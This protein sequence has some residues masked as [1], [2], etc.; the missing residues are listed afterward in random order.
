[1]KATTLIC[2][3]FMSIIF[4]AQAFAEKTI[5]EGKVSSDGTPT[6]SIP[7]ILHKEYQIKVT[8]FVNLGKWIQNRE[9]L[10]NDACYEFSS[11]KEVA[12]IDAVKNSQGISVC[13]GTYHQDHVYQSA[14]F[15]AKQN[16]IHFW[17]NDTD[18][19]DNSGS[20]HVE[21]IQIDDNK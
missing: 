5:W 7:L 19:D 6:K 2:M 18:Y 21:V 3:S 9:K 15:A 8:G 13:D 10:A 12:K 16:R 20:L 1:M 17:A 11:E 4:S 14:K